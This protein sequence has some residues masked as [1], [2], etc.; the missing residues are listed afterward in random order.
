MK[1]AIAAA[2]EWQIRSTEFETMA[3]QST[4]ATHFWPASFAERGVAVPFTTPSVAM[5]R[6]RNGE[7]GRL[8]LVISGL[9][10][11]RGVY[12]I[13]WKGVP[14]TFK[15]TVFDRVLHEHISEIEVAT[16]QAVH[17]AAIRASVTGLAGEDAAE[18]AYQA[19]TRTTEDELHVSLALT[20]LVVQK[21]LQTE[22]E[23]SLAALSLPSG[24]EKV[25]NMLGR[26]ARMLTISPETLTDA[27]TEWAERLLPLGVPGY[28]PVGKLR[29]VHDDADHFL[30]SF[31]DWLRTS[32]LPEGHPAVLI[33]EVLEETLGYWQGTFA[34]IDSLTANPTGTLKNWTSS[35]R[36]LEQLSARLPWLVDGWPTI[37]AIWETALR[38]DQDQRLGA[39]KTILSGIPLLPRDE[40]YKSSHARWQE[41]AKRLGLVAAANEERGHSDIELQGMLRQEKILARS[42]G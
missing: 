31:H 20:Q 17:E 5:A 23:L 25:Q 6:V 15:L 9:S 14:E 35:K 42:F 16:P 39:V 18:A 1:V 33:A 34:Q 11:G 8:E 24:Q 37:F 3:A 2:G 12:M 22:L 10:G 7:R 4:T 13:A 26:I 30:R 28:Q 40:V 41:F 19:S 27:M 21:V 36:E 29:K 32:E 38:G